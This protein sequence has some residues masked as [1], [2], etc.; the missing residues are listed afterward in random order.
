MFAVGQDGGAG[1]RG[2]AGPRAA[3]A[4]DD[5]PEENLHQVDE[6]RLH[7]ERGETGRHEQQK[8]VIYYLFF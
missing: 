5:R 7:Q 8:T 6:Q 2:R 3:G 1:G 4:E